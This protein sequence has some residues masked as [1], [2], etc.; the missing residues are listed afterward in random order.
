MANKVNQCIRFE[1]LIKAQG[2]A[3]ATEQSMCFSEWIRHLV[4]E[5]ITKHRKHGRK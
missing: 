5:A 2:A 1:P 4:R 3:I